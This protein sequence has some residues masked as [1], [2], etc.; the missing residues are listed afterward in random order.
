MSHGGGTG[1]VKWGQAEGSW[2]RL[3]ELFGQAVAVSRRRRSAWVEQACGGDADLRARLESLLRAHDEVQGA[4]GATGF[5]GGLDPGRAAALVGGYAGGGS[6]A[7]APPGVDAPAEPEAI[8]R[9]RILRRLGAGGMGVVY[10]ARDPA[11]DRLAAVKV[12]APHLTPDSAARARFIDEARA[13]SALDHPNVATIYEIG[14]TGDGRLFI[15]M[16]FCEGETLRQRLSAGPLPVDQ[17]VD[18]GVQL[19]RGLGA[20]HARGIVHRDVK[21][22]NVLVSPAGVVKLVDFGIAGAATAASPG[23]GG[24]LGTVAYM[25]PEQ[26]R[27]DVV[28]ERSDVWSLG[29]VLHEMLAGRR[30]PGTGGAAAPAGARGEA[31]EPLPGA[32]LPAGL[33][34]VVARCLTAEPAGRFAS[35]ADVAD[36]LAHVEIDVAARPLARRLAAAGLPPVTPP[37]AR[38]GHGPRDRAAASDGPAVAGR[39][40]PRTH[41]RGTRRAL[42]AAAAVA[43][44]ATASAYLA[45]PALSP[46]GRAQAPA[47]EERGWLLVADVDRTSDDAAVAGAVREALA[48]DLQQSRF[49]NVYGRSQVAAVLRSMGEPGGV[50]VLPLALEVA[51]RLGAEAVLSVGAAPMGSDYLLT[52]RA[53]RPGT[54]E[55]LF[56]VRASAAP[57]RLVEGVER[58]S[59]TVRRHLGEERHAVRRSRPLPDV[60]T[61]STDALRLYAQAEHAAASRD[62]EAAAA[63]LAEAVRLDPGF[64]MAHRAAGIIANNQLRFGDAAVHL[65]KAWRARE[66]LTDRERWHIEALYHSNVLLEPRRA[67]EA[68]RLLLARYPDDSRAAIN[69][70]TV[71][72][73][74]FND[75]E[76]A[77]SALSRVDRQNP[78]AWP[79]F[80]N[81]AQIAFQTGRLREA[82]EM[83]AAAGE[84]GF[85]D[86][87]SRW[88]IGT[89]F[90][91]G[92]YADALAACD[93][94]LAAPPRPAGTVDDRELCGS[95]DVAAGR[96]VTAEARLQDVVRRY[97]QARRY[98]NVAH[99]A[100]ALA[101][102]HVLRGEPERAAAP[103]ETVLARVPAPAV[104]EP[105]RFI[106]RTSLQLEAALLDRPDLVARIGQA[107]PPY[108]DAD[109]W[110]ARQGTALVQ[111]AVAVSSGNGQA[112]LAEMR[113]AIPDQRMPF[114]WRI[115]HDLLTGLAFEAVGQPDSAAAW[116]RAASSP[117]YL[118]AEALT[119]DRIHLPM[120]LR[121]LAAVEAE[122]GDTRAAADAYRRLL[123]LWHGAD[124]SLAGEVATIRAALQ[125]LERSGG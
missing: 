16:A 6:A 95:I 93:A 45:W 86:V 7:A 53:L 78:Q 102:L 79:F 113:R 114:G 58:L 22:E 98:R 50:L 17:A 105:D 57:D 8:G 32:R 20:A 69:L 88:Q 14:A 74:W 65:E 48:V 108:P 89:S 116:L 56:A 123:D 99:V 12:L 19:A 72:H 24:R 81:A 77:W 118:A 75:A 91:L 97:Y 68:Y 39:S 35:A 18:I 80:G 55:E 40:I 111:A 49:V 125:H 117:A 1:R 47:L 112:A 36:A 84:H 67:A 100:Q 96:L 21:P 38:S 115:W 92:R 83:A 15:A 66:R 37:G 25:S 3:E 9:H 23:P 31:P 28:D 42:L 54:A 94:V 44:L 120:V 52:A 103:I 34:A 73:T 61:R 43:V 82:G 11:L 30:P 124:P 59:R 104:G 70:A 76:E 51:E 26:A 106:S 119:K 4:G 62:D 101:Q 90:A 5:L 64:A 121:R 85:H 109:H 71:V 29:V 13:A 63:L 110:L 60:T 87:A 122:R 107:Y 27:G 33:E 46:A 2:R 41:R 10:L